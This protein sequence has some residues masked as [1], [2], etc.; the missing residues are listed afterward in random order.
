MLIGGLLVCHLI[1]T[2]PVGD[3]SWAW[4]D[5]EDT[6]DDGWWFVYVSPCRLYAW[7]LH[8]MIVHGLLGETSGDGLS[9]ADQM[10]VGNLDYSCEEQQYV[11]MGQHPVQARTK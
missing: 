7:F 4:D 8:L 1:V 2:S 5:W 11:C 10:K 6:L 3:C 9:L